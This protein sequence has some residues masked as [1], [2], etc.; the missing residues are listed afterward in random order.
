MSSWWD[1]PLCKQHTLPPFPMPSCRPA[2]ACGT[3]WRRCPAAIPQRHWSRRRGRRR[4]RM[5]SRGWRLRGQQRWWKRQRRRRRPACWRRQRRPHPS[6]LA[7]RRPAATRPV[8]W[9]APAAPWGARRRRRLG[10]L[11]LDWLCR[12][13]P[14]ASPRLGRWMWRAGWMPF[15][16][17]CSSGWA[18]WSRWLERGQGRLASCRRQQGQHQQQCGL[19]LRQ[20][21][22]S[23]HRR[24]QNRRSQRRM[25]HSPA[26]CLPAAAVQSR[27]RWP[28]GTASHRRVAACVRCRTA[29]LLSL[30]WQP[31]PRYP[32]L[33]ASPD[34][35]CSPPAPCAPMPSPCCCCSPAACWASQLLRLWQPPAASWPRLHSWPGGWPCRRSCCCGE[36]PSACQRL[37]ADACL[38]G[39]ASSAPRHSDAACLG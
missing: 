15:W 8:A 28:P 38:E 4:R 33:H 18:P 9:A 31:E 12:H 17:T 5:R 7:P 25:L 24:W 20:L 14:P 19:Q 3:A 27:Q 22:M 23:R 37:A 21:W 32:P 34:P 11:G 2:R 36:H 29:C 39:A 30:T 26:V 35:V 13:C 1:P 6:Q 10:R 16:R